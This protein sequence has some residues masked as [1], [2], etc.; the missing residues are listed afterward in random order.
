MTKTAGRPDVDLFIKEYI[1]R[2]LK[3]GKQCA[4]KA[5]YSEKTAEQQA[6]RLLKS[7]KVK[8]AIK[9]HQKTKMN[10]F[11][12][13]KEKK[14]KLIQEVA[15]N[16]MIKDSEQKMFNPQGFMSAIKEHNLMQGDNA[17]I[18]TDSTQS[19]SIQISFE[20]V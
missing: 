9:E 11:I 16:C 8:A 20:D 4:I 18:L 13:S 10:D 1:L 12:W 17:P 6:S 15:E 3:N 7:V 2:G 14:L 5:G 19:Q